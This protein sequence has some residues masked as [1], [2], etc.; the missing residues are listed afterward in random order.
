VRGLLI[1]IDPGI[2]AL[3]WAAFRE[4]TLIAAG[5]PKVRPLRGFTGSPG[6]GDKRHPNLGEIARV[7]V[8]G[9]RYGLEGTGPRGSLSVALEHMQTRGR[10]ARERPND[11]ID[12][13]A[14]GAACA[15]M[16]D[17]FPLRLITAQEWKGSVPKDVHHPR[18]VRALDPAE[19]EIAT[20]AWTAAGEN[21]KEVLDA[22]GIG[23]YATGRIDAKGEALR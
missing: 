23:L 15:G 19:T 8:H 16:L 2:W 13:Q 11:L 5:C 6:V 4:R 21:A 7:H 12:V 17:P 9:I 10:D 14:V 1:A 22:I 18:I 20:R 3:G